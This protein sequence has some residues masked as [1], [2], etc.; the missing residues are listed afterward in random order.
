M[1]KNLSVCCHTQAGSKCPSSTPVT[2]SAPVAKG[3]AALVP[4]EADQPPAPPGS[5]QYMATLSATAEMSTNVRIEH[6]VSVCQG[7]FGMTVLQPLP[8]PFHTVSSHPRAEADFLS[9]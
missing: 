8:P 2:A 1:S 7:G 9:T 6:P 3:E 4:P 5:V